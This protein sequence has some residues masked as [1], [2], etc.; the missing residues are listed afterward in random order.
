MRSLDYH[1]REAGQRSRGRPT[2]RERVSG[3][4]QK[5][6]YVCRL[7]AG[8]PGHAGEARGLELSQEREENEERERCEETGRRPSAPQQRT[9]GGEADRAAWPELSRT[10]ALDLRLSVGGVECRR[11]SRDRTPEQ[12][13]KRVATGSEGDALK[14]RD[15]PCGRWTRETTQESQRATGE[16]EGRRKGAMT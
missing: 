12:G 2:E 6:T 16:D 4:T 10:A 11:A 8:A 9:R 13:R 14:T 5:R 7:A 3:G 1:T 15:R